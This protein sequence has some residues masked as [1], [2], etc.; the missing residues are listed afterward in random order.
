MFYHRFP[1]F[2]NIRVGER[3]EVPTGS[4]DDDTE[5]VCEN[6]VCYKR[7]K[8]NTNTSESTATVGADTDA[9][10][11]AAALIASQLSNEEKLLRAKELI[12]KK[13][14]DKDEEDAR[15][16]FCFRIPPIA[17]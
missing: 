13:R 10:V 4:N 6:G 12:E 3:S 8:Q 15:V 14:K 7:P 1:L 16:C 5:I 11:D 2:L 17:I 9:D